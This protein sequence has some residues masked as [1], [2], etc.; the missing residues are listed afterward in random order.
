MRTAVYSSYSLY[1]VVEA[2]NR[3]HKPKTHKDADNTAR[4]I[5]SNVKQNLKF[6]KLKEQ[7]NATMNTPK[8]V[9]RFRRKKGVS[10]LE[11]TDLKIEPGEEDTNFDNSIQEWET[12]ELVVLVDAY[13]LCGQWE[14]LKPDFTSG[15]LSTARDKLIDYLVMYNEVR[16][17]KVVAVFDAVKSGRRTN[18]ENVFGV[19]IIYT[20]GIEADDWISREVES[21]KKAGSPVLVITSDIFMKSELLQLGA[22]VWN[23][24]TFVTEIQDAELEYSEIIKRDRA[25]EKKSKMPVKYDMPLAV[26][27]L[28]SLKKKL[29]DEDLSNA[30]ES[31]TLSTPDPTATDLHSSNQSNGSLRKKSVQI[32]KLKKRG[33]GSF[34]HTMHDLKRRIS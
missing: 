26:P 31:E 22:Y 4:R 32:V 7:R 18:K 15:R 2:S 27:A 9:T 28:K 5:T 13:N 29:V 16:E 17:F 25:R 3:K 1:P 24:D 14:K 19:D 23:C 8:P 20:G 33:Y 10:E 34:C 12:G 21:L 30:P 6:V 11:E